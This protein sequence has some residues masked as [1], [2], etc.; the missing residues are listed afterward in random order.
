LR[1]V[2]PNLLTSLN[3]LCGVIGIVFT[4]NQG[5]TEAFYLIL[6]AAVFD[7]FDGFAARLLKVKS[8]FGAELDSL[9]DMVTFGVL[10][11]IMLFQYL[12]ISQGN[13]FTPIYERSTGDLIV[14]FIG[15]LVPIFSALRLAKFNIDTNQTSHFLGLPTPANAIFIGSL[16]FIMEIQFNLNYYI[17]I[18]NEQLA[19]VTRLNYWDRF[20]FYTVL[21]F[22]ETNFHLV[23]ALGLSALLVSRIPLFSLKLKSL[24]FKENKLVF[25]YL[26]FMISIV[27]LNFLPYFVPIKRWISIW[28]HLDFLLIPLAIIFYIIFSL[29]GYRSF[30]HEIQS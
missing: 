4:F 3:L 29:I 10:P 26:I 23:L 8:D 18:A 14:S 20:E 13:Y 15:F 24:K 11:G 27:L 16:G 2:I 5:L 25:S 7:F 9:A 17:P 30:N 22:F 1:A 21:G 28:V 12:S 6:L 19:A